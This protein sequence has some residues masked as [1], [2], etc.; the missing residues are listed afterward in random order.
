MLLFDL[1]PDK[2]KNLLPKNGT[3]N[4]YGKVISE[5]LAI[6]FY[7]TLL[8]EIAWKNDEA[9]IFGKHIITKRKV[10]WYGDLPFV[11]TYSHS[12]KK[13][14][15]WND[16][17]KN[18]KSIAEK[19]TGKSFNSCLLNLYHDGQE[20]MSWHSDDED[21]LEPDASIVSI[22]FGAA[23]KFSFQHKTNK[24][25]QSILL[26]N[27]SLLVMESNV[28]K[29]WLHALPKSKRISSPRINLTF[30]TMKMSSLEK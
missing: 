27:G 3:V 11:Y 22:S 4:Y 21:T 13:A 26:E 29:N 16:V 8:E 2:T 28:Q 25:S 5:P 18:I 17:L 10:G 6:E 24:T 15:P 1:P 9:V 20:G 7:K 12:A 14:L 30:R 23:R 19:H